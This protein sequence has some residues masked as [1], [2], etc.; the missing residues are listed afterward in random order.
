MIGNEDDLNKLPAI[1][2]IYEKML[3]VVH[4][5]PKR[6]KE[7]A[8]VVKRLDDS[9]IGD[10]FMDMYSQFEQAARRLIK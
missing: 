8:D 6:L 10:E 4:Q 2:A 9:I 3:K 7:I 1:S 5:N